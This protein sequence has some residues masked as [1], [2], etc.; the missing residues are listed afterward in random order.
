MLTIDRLG[1]REGRLQILEDV[2]FTWPQGLLAVIGGNGSGKTTL[3][4]VVA[5]AKSPN[6][7]TAQWNN[8]PTTRAARRKN[9]I[10][11]G[12]QERNLDLAITLREFLALCCDLRG[13]GGRGA[14][15][16]A[17]ATELGL[18]KQLDERLAN[19]SGGGRRK[20]MTAQALLGD[21][22]LIVL[23]EPTSEVD[24]AASRRFW[25]A[26]K[27]RGRSAALLVAT[28]DV[29]L[30][31]ATAD[32]ILLLQRGHPLKL[33]PAAEFTLEE[34]SAAIADD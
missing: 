24:Y 28:H 26:F 27:T 16:E 15:I 25:A 34:L 6:T 10:G 1:R 9:Q 18:S 17:V 2:T 8:L 11:Y 12:P 7:G 4:R 29:E 3:L 30:A 19:L 23:D 13:L 5:G 14:K 21:P 31:L 32:S 20:A 22:E 33:K